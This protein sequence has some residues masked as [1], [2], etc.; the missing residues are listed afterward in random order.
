VIPPELTEYLDDLVGRLGAVTEL[1]AVYLFGSAAQGAY[2]HGRSDVDVIAVTEQPSS[3]AVKE[4]LAAAAESLPCP[5]RK[6]ELVVYARAG[7]DRHELNVN[8]GELVHYSPDDDPA[9]W[10]VLDRSIA[11]QHAVPLLGPPWHDVFAPVPRAEVEAALD[12][13]LAFDGWDEA[14][15]RLASAR[16]Q[17]W[18]E[19]GRW[20]SKREAAARA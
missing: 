11:E 14:N 4:A 19:S 6:L 3:Q 18:R 9:F 20:V 2:E 16:A 1:H 7:L 10:F 12:E 17:I 15:A 13:A 8:T 5:A